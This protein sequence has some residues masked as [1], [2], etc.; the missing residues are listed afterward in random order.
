MQTLQTTVLALTTLL[1]FAWPLAA[2]VAPP[3][4]SAPLDSPAQEAR[5]APETKC[6][7]DWSEASA[8]VRREALLPVERIS[9]L[10]NAKYPGASIIKLTLCEEQ[11]KFVY[12]LLLRERQG[13]L[14]SELLDAR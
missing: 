5:G 11:G 13:Q 6:W 1:V 2:Q 10:A 7:T 4:S 12:H 8:V 3:A 9:K 14:K